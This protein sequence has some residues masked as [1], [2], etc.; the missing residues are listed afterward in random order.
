MTLK[1]GDFEALISCVNAI[2][3][4]LTFF[5]ASFKKFREFIGT[6][7]KLAREWDLA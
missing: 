6:E 1:W 5:F 3:F 4:I 7:K 2:S